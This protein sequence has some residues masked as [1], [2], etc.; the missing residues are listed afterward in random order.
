MKDSSFISNVIEAVITYSD[1]FFPDGKL[2][3]LLLWTS[4]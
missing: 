1:W 2:H 4:A 3:F